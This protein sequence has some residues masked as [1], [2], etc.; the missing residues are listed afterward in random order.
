MKVLIFEWLCGGGQ[1]LEGTQ[2]DT[3]NQL[4]IQGKAMLQA[5]EEDFSALQMQVILPLDSRI[6]YESGSQTK[7]IPI[8][9]KASLQTELQRLAQQ[10]DYILLIA[11]ETAGTLLHCS[12][13]FHA[14]ENKLI[15]PPPATIE[16]LTDKS[17]TCKLLK[18]NSI[19]TTEG[20]ILE[21][22]GEKINHPAKALSN[23]LPGVL[24]P[25]DGAGSETTFFIENLEKLL[26]FT[27]HQDVISAQPMRLEKWV[28][29][30]SASTSLIC[31]PGGCEI[32]PA[33]RQVFQSCPIGNYL[34][35]RADLCNEH[36]RRA[37]QLAIQVYQALP[38][39]VGYLG[40]D[41]ILG[42]APEDDRVIEIN[43]RLTSSYPLLRSVS[44]RNLAQTMLQMAKG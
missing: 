32:L 15:S 1:W 19:P 39:T 33:T 17:K 38:K 25:N 3:H 36:R 10:A 20:I 21:T 27:A 9:N 22:D 14:F 24:K 16:L 13:W 8:T 43:P 26:Q 11:P 37:H 34:E 35:N 5:V 4:Q 31:G 28:P 18:E 23:L 6:N 30:V 29:G 40:I 12:K 2:L 7:T 44:S 41:L 42:D